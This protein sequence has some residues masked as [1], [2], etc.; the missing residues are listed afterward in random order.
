[1]SRI[2]TSDF[3]LLRISE[4]KRAISSECAPRSWKKLSSIET[5]SIFITSVSARASAASVSS[6]GATMLALPAETRGPL[7]GGRFLRSGLV[8]DDVGQ[9]GHSVIEH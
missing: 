6:R 5:R 4:Q 8:L 9:V 7:G 3:R 2:E 1:M